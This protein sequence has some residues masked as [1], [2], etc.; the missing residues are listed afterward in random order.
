MAGWSRQKR[1]Q[2]EANV[3]RLKARDDVVCIVLFDADGGEMLMRYN[4]Q[5][6]QEPT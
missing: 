3:A 6:L 1:E 5:H 2:A 4:S